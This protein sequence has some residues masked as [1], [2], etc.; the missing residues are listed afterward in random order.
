MPN[1]SDYPGTPLKADPFDTSKETSETSRTSYGS[2]AASPSTPSSSATSSSRS[3][4]S[5][6]F[7]DERQGK[8]RQTQG[9]ERPGS[10]SPRGSESQASSAGQGFDF[11]E[12]QERAGKTVKAAYDKASGFA[13]EN[14][15]LAAGI[16]IG[17]GA[18]LLRRMTRR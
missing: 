18:L 9:G 3:T 6:A 10:S 1:Q 7:E 8:S 5:N 15:R 16:G 2:G 4:G 12:L 17:L 14:P 11:A 13:R